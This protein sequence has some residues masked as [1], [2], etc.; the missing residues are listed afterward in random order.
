MNKLFAEYTTNTA[1]DFRLSKNMC[2]LL[3]KFS[4]GESWGMF[5][6][7]ITCVHALIDRGLVV[8]VNEKRPR[9][10]LTRAGTAVVV[11]LKEAGM[12]VSNVGGL[13]VQRTRSL[14]R[15]LK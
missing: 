14:E 8:H 15:Q 10:E 6:P 5:S 1:F 11:L 4:S 12:T 13:S 2:W 9:F 7:F 3:L